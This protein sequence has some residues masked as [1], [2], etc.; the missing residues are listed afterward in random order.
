MPLKTPERLDLL[1]TMTDGLG[2]CV[3]VGQS[4]YQETFLPAKYHNNLLLARWDSRQVTRYPLENRGASFK[5]TEQHFLDG[6]NDARPVG[7]C[8]G[9]GGRVFATIA[10]MN[11]NEES[12]SPRS[13]LGRWS[14][15][16]PTIRCCIRSGAMQRHGR[17]A[18]KAVARTLRSVVEPA[19]PGS[20]GDSAPRRAAIV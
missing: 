12:I 3:P 7:V 19:L 6:R 10:F 11:H 2:R 5:T 17:G 8:V 20:L 18:R 14:R 13:E 9:R 16:G 1:D 4:Y 15:A